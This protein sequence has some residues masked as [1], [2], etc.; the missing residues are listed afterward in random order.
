MSDPAAIAVGEALTRWA[1]LVHLAVI[2]TLLLVF[3]ALYAGSRREVIG[4]WV[5]AWTGN[6]VAAAAQGTGMIVP[7]TV[8]LPGLFCIGKLIFALLMVRGLMQFSRDRLAMFHLSRFWAVLGATAVCVVT[9]LFP[10][11]FRTAVTFGAAGLVLLIGGPLS[12]LRFRRATREVPDRDGNPAASGVFPAATE[13]S[14]PINDARLLV[15]AT[16]FAGLMDVYHGSMLWIMHTSAG[17]DL[18]V[19]PVWFSDAFGDFLIGLGALLALGQRALGEMR[20]TNL[21][22]NA[23]QQTLRSLVD[24][25]PLTGLFNRRRL[26]KTLKATQESGGCLVVLDID[27][28]KTVNDRWGHLTGDRCLRRVADALRSVFRAEDGLF[29]IGGDEFLVVVPALNAAEVDGRIDRLRGML[30]P[31]EHNV[32]PISVSVGVVELESGLPIDEALAL[33]DAAMYSEKLTTPERKTR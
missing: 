30:K 2:V 14:A 13:I 33:A 23:T 11:D 7:S 10:T 25:D 3:L 16:M 18:L 26:R 9:A 22:L 8:I 17:T 1:V 21:E 6:L 19:R 4:T 5:A 15:F 32:I 29:R 31:D 27:A 12:A 24:A 28:F 20:R